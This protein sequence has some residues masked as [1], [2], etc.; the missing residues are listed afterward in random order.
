LTHDF[1]FA[2]SDA[3][4]R[5]VDKCLDFE[6]KV[7]LQNVFLCVAKNM[8]DARSASKFFVLCAK[9]RIIAKFVNC[10]RQVK[11]PPALIG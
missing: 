6:V 2:Q 4:N 3:P 1:P 9:I 5:V 7:D 8:K 10:L 11:Q